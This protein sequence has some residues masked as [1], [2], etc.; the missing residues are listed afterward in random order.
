MINY[1]KV[2]RAVM[3]C[4]GGQ[5]CQSSAVSLR[6]QIHVPHKT[7]I[8]DS[9]VKEFILGIFMRYEEYL[10]CVNSGLKIL[11]NLLSTNALHLYIVSKG[12]LSRYM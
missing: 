12:L 8:F 9:T 11:L 2:K 1:N 7:S 10:Y 5:L 3:C 6:V 4:N